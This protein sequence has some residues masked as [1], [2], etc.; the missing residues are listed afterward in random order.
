MWFVWTEIFT[1]FIN[2]C[3]KTKLDPIDAAANCRGP[4]FKKFHL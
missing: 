2:I 1:F 3:F 4:K